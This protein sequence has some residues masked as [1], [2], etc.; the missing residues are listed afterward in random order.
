MDG[1]I[2][3]AGCGKPSRQEK[4]A[5][6]GKR[7]NIRIGNQEIRIGAGIIACLFLSYFVPQIQRLAACT[8]VV[9]CTQEIGQATLKSG[10]TRL[11]G[12]VCGGAAGIAVVLLDQVIQI[13]FVFFI[14]CGIGIVL[15]LL[16]C[17]LLHMPPVTDRVSAITFCLVVLLAEGN[18]RIFYAVSRFVG[19]LAGALTALIITAIWCTVKKKTQ[20][21][22]QNEKT[23]MK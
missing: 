2:T 7:L 12:V 17:R 22:S 19:T 15:N 20:G 9:M 4:E 23:P 5:D 10:L 13:D 16:I 6:G 11:K 14:L 3:A 1:S 21:S 8:A 18:G